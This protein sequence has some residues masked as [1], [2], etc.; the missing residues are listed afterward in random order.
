MLPGADI[1][2]LPARFDDT[3]QQ[4]FRQSPFEPSLSSAAA[5]LQS[6]FLHDRHWLSRS[7]NSDAFI[8]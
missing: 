2:P 1:P 7:A 5:S 8:P 4:L 3:G 6:V